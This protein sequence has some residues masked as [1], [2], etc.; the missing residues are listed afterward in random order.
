VVAQSIRR[1]R[2]LDMPTDEIRAVLDAPDDETRN[3]LL[4]VHLDRMESRLERTRSTV[5]GLRSLLEAP[6]SAPAVTDR[7]LAP[8]LAIA[9]REQVSFDDAAAWCDDAYGELHALLEGRGA[10]ASGPDGAL[11]PTSFFEEGEGEV[12]A[13]VPVEGDV[14]TRGRVVQIEVPGFAAAVAVHAGSFDDLDRTYRVLGTAVAERG[15]GAE[16]PMREH[17]LDDDTIEVCWPIAGR[18]ELSR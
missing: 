2:E 11:Y 4:V 13:F 14:P 17:Y 5:A 15:V 6:A 18:S 3:A 1:F 7:T 16:G 8:T 10:V 9:I 12:T